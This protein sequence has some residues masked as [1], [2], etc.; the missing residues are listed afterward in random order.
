MI[1]RS[2]KD[3]EGIFSKIVFDS[4]LP[5]VGSGSLVIENWI[6]DSNP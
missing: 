4:D 5:I 1:Y 2:V 6:L 3:H